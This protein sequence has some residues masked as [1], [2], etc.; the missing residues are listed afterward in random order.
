MTGNERTH[1][2][3][4]PLSK[5]QLDALALAAKGDLVKTNAG[6]GLP[7]ARQTRLTVGWYV[8]PQTVASLILRGLLFIRTRRTRKEKAVITRAGRRALEA[9]HG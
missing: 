7:L 4:R 8:S 9:R 5:A 1:T 3:P 6:W 2:W